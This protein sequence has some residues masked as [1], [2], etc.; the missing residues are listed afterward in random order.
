MDDFNR[1]VSRLCDS[2]TLDHS[3]RLLIR[4]KFMLAA[5]KKSFQARVQNNALSAFVKDASDANNENGTDIVGEDTP[6]VEFPARR[7]SATSKEISI[8]LYSLIVSDIP[9]LL[10]SIS[11]LGVDPLLAAGLLVFI[12]KNLRDQIPRE[13]LENDIGLQ[14]LS[15]ELCKSDSSCPSQENMKNMI[16]ILAD[17]YS[18]IGGGTNGLSNSIRAVA[19]HY[20][21]A[22]DP[23]MLNAIY[24]AS[25]DSPSHMSKIFK[26]TS[27]MMKLILHEYPDSMYTLVTG[28]IN[29]CAPTDSAEN[30]E[31]AMSQ[32]FKDL[33][34]AYKVREKIV[35]AMYGLCRGKM[36]LVRPLGQ[37]FGEFET[38]KTENFFKLIMRLAPLMQINEEDQQDEAGNGDVTTLEEAVS[39]DV[40]FARVD[41]HGTGYITLDE[42]GEAMK[43]Y[44]INL[45]KIGLMKLFLSGDEEA[46]GLLTPEKFGEIISSFEENMVLSV[47]DSLG[48]GMST[49][50][51][52]V[53]VAI[54]FILLLFGF[55]FVGLSTFSKPGAFGA[56]TSS[57]LFLGIGNS[58]GED[59]EDDDEDDDDEDGGSDELVEALTENMEIIE[60]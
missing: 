56:A 14:K 27:T 30:Q 5:N 24:F 53:L 46:E 16:H 19:K 31:K 37:E 28:L 23:V 26:S 35:K 42:F 11:I 29:L 33:S 18:G 51:N 22:G 57:S 3:G 34:K 43:M 25:V 39:P 59:D 49:L 41:K 13:Y 55:L 6:D 52:A 12:N 20:L 1:V 15:E 48:K 50:F 21:E 40:V 54:A 7:S 8:L 38:D 45:N 10:E 36:K 4:G 60:E 32:S 58:M 9:K 44:Q 2:A 47:M 17:G